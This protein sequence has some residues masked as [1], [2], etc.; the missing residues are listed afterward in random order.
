[1]RRPLPL[2][3][4]H[5]GRRMTFPIDPRGGIATTGRGVDPQARAT[6]PRDPGLPRATA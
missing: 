4:I 5:L 1:M 6:H 3:A 2:P